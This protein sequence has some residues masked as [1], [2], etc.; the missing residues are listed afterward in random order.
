MS[1]NLIQAVNASLPEN[2]SVELSKY[3]SHPAENTQS[4]MNSIIPV[5]LGAVSQYLTSQEQG[6]K[7]V[8]QLSS[9]EIP[10]EILS[11]SEQLFDNDDMLN[12]F[13][14]R[15]DALTGSILP[16]K[17]DF[18]QLIADVGKI[19]R[20]A[21]GKVCN[22]LTPFIVHTIKQSLPK[23]IRLV[24]LAKLFLHQI[25]TVKH[26][27][28]SGTADLLNI[29]SFDNLALA[30]QKVYEIRLPD[31]P[32][33]PKP[34][35]KGASFLRKILPLLLLVLVTT[36]I[37][38]FFEAEQKEL[39]ATQHTAEESLSSFQLP[40]GEQVSYPQESVEAH[41]AE[42]MIHRVNDSAYSITTN[43]WSITSEGDSLISPDST[44]L[45]AIALL[46]NTHPEYK[47]RL[48]TI[49]TADTATD[50]LE[51]QVQLLLDA[52]KTQL[53]AR[54]IQSDRIQIPYKY[55]KPEAQDTAQIHTSNPVFRLTILHQ[56]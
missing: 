20:D 30:L 14:I 1:T 15:G 3:I 2:F 47:L 21:A 5:W 29:S 24:D 4:A 22:L 13:L 50:T 55:A 45:D 12:D 51:Q 48:Q 32:A 6:L 16:Q 25:K 42:F 39:E 38:Y 27:A 49:S 56:D 33:P 53:V 35:T 9:F 44:Q 46:F 43:D 10:T 40:S 19:D 23:R 8:D 36:L 54:G 18:Y 52:I 37:Y 11:S 26:A 7:L 41:I 31:I 17:T 34:P 28:P